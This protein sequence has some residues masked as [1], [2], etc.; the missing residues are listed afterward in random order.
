MQDVGRHYDSLIRN[1]LEP[2]QSLD[3]GKHIIITDYS[4]LPIIMKITDMS[5]LLTDYP[6]LIAHPT[7][8]KSI[9]L[10]QLFVRQGKHKDEVFCV[11]INMLGACHR[12]IYKPFCL[13]SLEFSEGAQQPERD[14]P[15]APFRT[16]QD[17]KLLDARHDMVDCII[18]ICG[19]T[20]E[21]FW[22]ADVDH[23]I[24]DYMFGGVMERTTGKKPTSKR[25]D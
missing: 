6:M 2:G 7:L 3:R 24:D 22:R 1:R 4:Q 25:D 17:G 8:R 19:S 10:F 9:G 11:A 16:G 5:E 13:S 14:F 18:G 15:R 12:V 23:V 20:F 21:E